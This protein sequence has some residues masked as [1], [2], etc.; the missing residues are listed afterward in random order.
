[1]AMLLYISIYTAIA[2]LLYMLLRYRA[3]AIGAAICHR[4]AAICRYAIGPP[5][6]CHSNAATAS[7]EQYTDIAY[8]EHD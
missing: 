4:A 6:C 7:A 1:M 8:A 2:M 5:P 3:A